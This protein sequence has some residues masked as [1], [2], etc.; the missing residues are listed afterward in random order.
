MIAK[1]MQSKRGTV[2]YLQKF[3]IGDTNMCIMCKQSKEIN[4]HALCFCAHSTMV[5]QR[6]NSAVAI[7]LSIIKYG[8]TLAME[9]IVHTLYKPG[10]TGTANNMKIEELRDRN[11]TKIHCP[12][13]WTKAYKKG[14]KNINRTYIQ[15]MQARAV[16][17]IMTAGGITPLWVGVITKA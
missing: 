17:I 5:E 2:D 1:L 15:E 9:N 11:K 3:D 14:N 4:R 16:E 12:K 10:M 6:H 13:E 8:G 7:K